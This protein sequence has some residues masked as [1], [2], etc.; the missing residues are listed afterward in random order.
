MLFEFNGQLIIW[1][2]SSQKK[3]FN[4]FIFLTCWWKKK[5]IKRK[6]LSPP[7]WEAIKCHPHFSHHSRDP[8]KLPTPHRWVSADVSEMGTSVC[9]LVF[10]RTYVACKAEQ[11]CIRI[12]VPSYR[13]FFTLC[14]YRKLLCS[15]HPLSLM[16]LQF[17]D[18][19]NAR[20]ATWL[21][22]RPQSSAACWALVYTNHWRAELMLV[23]TPLSEAK[24]IWTILL[25]G[26]QFGGNCV[27]SELTVDR[28]IQD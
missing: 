20:P 6:L 17:T 4:S 19:Q 3:P 13:K 25:F 15:R 28:K 5:P 11:Q 18:G 12:H 9:S 21:E 2:L 1:H 14:L 16:P 24:A 22:L 7:W 8:F 23:L 26:V 10:I 27:E